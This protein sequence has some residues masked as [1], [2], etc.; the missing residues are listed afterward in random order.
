M[1]AQLKNIWKDRTPWGWLIPLL[2]SMVVFYSTMCRTVFVGDSGEFALVFKT[3]GIAHPPGYPLFSLLGHFFVMFTAFFKPAFSA[4]LF[5]VL[6]AAATLPALYLILEG[7]RS[8]LL[9]GIITLSW[10]FSPLFWRE[11]V[12]VEVY[13]FNIL[14]IAMIFALTMSD[15]N[16]KWFFIFYLLGLSLA[17]HFSAVIV[18]PA[19]LITYFTENKKANWKPVP[20]YVL[21]FLIG[22]SI[23]LYL[24]TR[25]SVSPLADWGHPV[26]L[27]LLFN[28]ITAAQYQHAAAFS[29]GNI[30]SSVILF[31]SL[32][33]QNWWWLGLLLLFGGIF[34]G[35]KENRNRTLFALILI[36]T[37]II[38]AAFYRIP[39]IDSYYLPALFASLVLMAES[40]FWIWEK[41]RGQ[42][43]RM[44]LVV[45]LGGIILLLLIHN[46]RDIDRSADYLARDYGKLILDTAGS[47]T[48][49]THD[50]N[51]SFSTLYLRYAEGYMPQVEVFDQ[52][53]LLHYVVTR[54]F[55]LTG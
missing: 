25:S 20:L 10:A 49:F 37:N 4:N 1:L 40:L 35:L 17:H 11:T 18:I 53:A 22:L 19:V 42:F 30:W 23:Y 3:L 14:L 5:S 27:T 26:N 46:Y 32:L 9:T 50:D 39:D 38:I 36:V 29:I 52:A 48:V 31:F 16:R 34:V 13:G 47:G 21:L 55:L 8:P 54:A 24:P 12:A 28:H 2:V 44:A 7:R 33:I 6:L 45:I 41:I 51:A 15:H 43:E